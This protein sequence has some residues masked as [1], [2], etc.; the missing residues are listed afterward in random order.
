M[1]FIKQSIEGCD[2]GGDGSSP[3]SAARF[4][5]AGDEPSPPPSCLRLN[6]KGLDLLLAATILSFAVPAVALDGQVQIHDPST[7]AQC[8]G[9]YYTFGTG[10][11]CL[12]SDDGWTWRRRSEERRVGK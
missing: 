5:K 12:I 1:Q 7:I 2:R 6:I 8:D 10:G 9:K 3:R 11:S 4:D